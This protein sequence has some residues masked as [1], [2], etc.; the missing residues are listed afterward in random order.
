MRVLI[1]ED[2]ETLADGLSV[3]LRLQGFTPELV[4]CC[5][6]AREALAQGGFSAV[7]LDLMLPDGSGLDLLAG[8]RAGGD[9]L[10][11]LLL[12]ALD[13]VR[14]RIGGLDAGADDYL[15]KPFDLGEVSAR[16]RAIIRRAEGRASALLEWNGLRLDPSRMSGEMEGRELRFSRR[17]FSVLRALI[18]TPGV[19]VEKD[20]LEERLYGWQ[21]GVESNAVEV[22]VHKLRGK[23]GAGFIETVRG[24]GYRL[25]EPRP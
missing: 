25:A 2:D 18:E 9:R 13:Q 24:V 10:P 3:G 5:A 23:L 8:L 17:E 21:E 7:V 22:H 12:T 20:R 11:V 1:V 14:D 15:G 19:I 6:D 4:T 16:L